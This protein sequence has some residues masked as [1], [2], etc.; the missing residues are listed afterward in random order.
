MMSQV[1]IKVN[2]D[3]EVKIDFKKTQL[4]KFDKKIETEIKLI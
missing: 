1:I 3:V 2:E 4:K